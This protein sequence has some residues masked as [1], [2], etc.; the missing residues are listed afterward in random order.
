MDQRLLKRP[1][2]HEAN[3]RYIIPVLILVAAIISIA[4]ND[5]PRG[6][7]YDC[8]LAEISPD[9][10]PQVKQECR[11]IRYE[12]WKKEQDE[13]KAEKSVYVDREDFRRFITRT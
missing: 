13:R 12:Q 11:R 4:T 8:N 9:Y 7:W 10:P 6:Q 3:V 2:V 1:L 5:L